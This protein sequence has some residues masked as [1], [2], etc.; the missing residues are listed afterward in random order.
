MEGFLK[1][2][3]TLLLE[4]NSV[5]AKGLKYTGPDRVTL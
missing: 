3:L 5:Q 4:V 1:V 2:P